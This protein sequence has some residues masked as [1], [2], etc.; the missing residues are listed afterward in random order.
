MEYLMLAKHWRGQFV[1]GWLASEK[2]DGMRAF[3]DGG[4]GRGEKPPWS[5]DK[6]IGTGLWSRYGKVIH[7]PVWWL[8]KLPNVCL[9]GELFSKDWRTTLS[10]TRA[11]DADWSSVTYNVFD[12]PTPKAFAE[13]RLVNNNIISHLMDFDWHE[14]WPSN[15]YDVS[16]QLVYKKLKE[17]AN[18]V[19]KI[20]QQEEITTYKVASRAADIVAAG[21]EGLMLRHPLS[22]WFP[23]RSGWLLKVK[24]Y[25]T[26][27]GEIVGYTKGKGKYVGMLGALVVKWEDVIFNLSGMTDKLR[28]EPPA[29]GSQVAFRHRGVSL[30]GVPREA[31]FIGVK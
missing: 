14:W 15:G 12:S 1:D 26:S 4:V 29:I 28:I 13:R 17:H 5:T 20:V 30:D 6:I 11:H 18:K 23:K 10:A 19:V 16:Y 22:S 31:R 24:P 27:I 8:D 25:D 21:G 9:D 2:L 7:A 3:W